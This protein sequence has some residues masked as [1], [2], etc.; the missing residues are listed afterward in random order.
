MWRNGPPSYPLVGM[1]T[2]IIH[3]NCSH[4]STAGCWARG[5][6]WVWRGRGEKELNLETKGDR[7]SQALGQRGRAGSFS[8]FPVWVPRPLQPPWPWIP[9]S[10]RSL[11]PLNLD[12][13]LIIFVLFLFRSLNRLESGPQLCFPQRLWSRAHLALALTLTVIPTRLFHSALWKAFWY[14]HKWKNHCL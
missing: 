8:S 10:P 13:S 7:L 2:G 14:K 1:Q 4:L 5:R 3:C 9:N 12:M 11:L 6:V